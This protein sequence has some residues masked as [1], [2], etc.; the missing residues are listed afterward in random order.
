MPRAYALIAEIPVHFEDPLE[1]AHDEALQV[2][3][4]RD[5]QVH[6]HVQ[7]VVVGDERLGCRAAGN[8]MQH[9]CFHFQE[10]RLQHVRADA[11]YGLA[12]R[13][14]RAAS[15][16]GHDQIDVTLAIAQFLICNTVKF[17]GKRPQCLTQ[18]PYAGGMNREFALVRLEDRA[19]DCNK[20]ADIPALEGGINVFSDCISIQEHLDAARAVLERGKAGFAHDALEHHAAG[21]LSAFVQLGQLVFLKATVGI[22]Q[23]G[24][25]GVW[26]EIVRIGDA[27]GAQTRQ[28]ATA[29]R[30]QAVIV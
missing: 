27:F 26:L 21:D 20:I 25:F 8:R 18:E 13:E 14:E 17:I 12:A 24:C 30:N 19:F 7:R 16:V 29:L 22:M 28:L 4:R 2:E 15:L 1:A 11:A 23:V 9:G 6:L 10:T 5:A 3:F